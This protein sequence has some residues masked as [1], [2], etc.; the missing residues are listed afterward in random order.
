ME[1][2]VR[3]ALI[4]FGGMGQ[5]YARML[6]AGMVPEMALTGVCCRNEARQALLKAGVPGGGASMPTTGRWRPTAQTLTR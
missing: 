6:H 1:N 4:G 3:A 5:I 2:R